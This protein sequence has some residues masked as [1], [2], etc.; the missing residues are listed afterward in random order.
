M[1]RD[2]ATEKEARF[3]EFRFG[4]FDRFRDISGVH[5]SLRDSHYEDLLYQLYCTRL[6][7]TSW[8]RSL[9]EDDDDHY[10]IIGYSDELDKL[11]RHIKM[12]RDLFIDEQAYFENLKKSKARHPD[13][14]QFFDIGTEEE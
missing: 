11:E 4:L 10:L 6:R 2:Y 14:Q 13:S 12:S 8:E 7:L 9:H 1:E 5:E 3:Q